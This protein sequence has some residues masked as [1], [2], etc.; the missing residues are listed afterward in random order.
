MNS[1]ISQAM[2]FTQ[3]VSAKQWLGTLAV[4]ALIASCISMTALYQDPF[5]HIKICF[6]GAVQTPE[7]GV[8]L[9]LGHCTWCY[10]GAGLGLAALIVPPKQ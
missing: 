3:D 10:L 8:F 6:G 5:A 1:H 7:I 4:L 2:T 9:L